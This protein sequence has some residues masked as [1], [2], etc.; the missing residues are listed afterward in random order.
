MDQPFCP[1][2]LPL[3]FLPYLSTVFRFKWLL[4]GRC[5]DVTETSYLFQWSSSSLEV[6]LYFILCVWPYRKPI[7]EENNLFE[8]FWTNGANG[9]CFV[10]SPTSLPK[11]RAA[12][13]LSTFSLPTLCLLFSKNH[14]KHWLLKLG[15]ERR[16]MT[17]VKILFHALLSKKASGSCLCSDYC[18]WKLKAMYI[19]RIFRLNSSL[20]TCLSVQHLYRCSKISHLSVSA[21]S[22][23]TARP[24]LTFVWTN[25]CLASCL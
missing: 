24:L 23:E 25:G 7:L 3:V 17:D 14:F 13:L 8:V 11:T 20:E 19:M 16:I 12:F 6:E 10:P 2:C 22:S 21:E 5:V 1:R 4:G 9:S 18:E 15:M